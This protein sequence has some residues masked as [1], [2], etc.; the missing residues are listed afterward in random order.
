MTWPVTSE[1][2]TVRFFKCEKRRIPGAVSAITHVDVRRLLLFQ[3]I[4]FVAPHFDELLQ[5]E[6]ANLDVGLAGQKCY[7]ETVPIPRA[8]RY[9]MT[10]LP[11]PAFFLSA[12]LRPGS[13]VVPSQLSWHLQQ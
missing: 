11:M 7:Q 12:D 9:Q 2:P 1:E 3:G 4:L 6:E 13:Y 8:S 5:L 10:L